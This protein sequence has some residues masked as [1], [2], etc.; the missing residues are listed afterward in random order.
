LSAS[1]DAAVWPFL[2]VT[3][4]GSS[5]TTLVQDA[6]GGAATLPL[7]SLPKG[8]SFEVILSDGLNSTRLNRPR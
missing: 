6:T 8:G 1:W 2:T 5:R 3:H 4:V 7:V